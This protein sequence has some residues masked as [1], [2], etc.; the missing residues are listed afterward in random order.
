VGFAAAPPADADDD[1]LNVCG[2]VMAQPNTDS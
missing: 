1:V 2:A